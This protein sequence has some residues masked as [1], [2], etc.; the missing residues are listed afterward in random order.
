[1]GWCMLLSVIMND[2]LRRRGIGRVIRCR[3]MIVDGS[4]LPPQA[5][6]I[7]TKV[8]RKLFIRSYEAVDCFEEVRVDGLTMLAEEVRERRVGVVDAANDDEV[9][10]EEEVMVLVVERT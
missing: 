1:M 3:A 5:A 6:N 9:G 10:G 7:E 8:A 4:L 2:L